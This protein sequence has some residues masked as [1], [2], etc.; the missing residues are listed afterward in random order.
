MFL[1]AFEDSFPPELVEHAVD[2]SDRVA[3]PGMPSVQCEFDRERAEAVEI[4]EERAKA[5]GD[6]LTN[7]PN[8]HAYSNEIRKERLDALGDAGD[9]DGAEAAFRDLAA[10][11]P[12]EAD[13]Y[14]TMAS[15]YIRHKTKLDEAL[16]LLDKAEGNLTA[17]GESSGFVVVLD[18][19]PDEDRATLN[20]WRGRA[21]L[22]LRQWTRAEDVFERS[23]RALDEAEPYA[24]MARAQEQQKKWWDAKNSYLEASVRFRRVTR[25]T[26]WSSSFV[27]P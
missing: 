11:V 23:A 22:Q 25:K 19:N 7:Y 13:L 2:I 12:S 6:W 27:F 21:F 14:A 20:L 18:D 10:R 24:L 1:I 15:I 5:L 4:S 8:D 3:V 26:M 17:D 16:T 9:I